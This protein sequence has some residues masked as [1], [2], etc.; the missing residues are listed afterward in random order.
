MGWM[1]VG[2]PQAD[3]GEMA[4]YRVVFNFRL[5]AKVESGGIYI[6]LAP[7]RSIWKGPPAPG[8]QAARGCNLIYT[9]V[10]WYP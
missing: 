4:G 3:Q 6:T 2:F 7:P 10:S 1:V 8:C 9:Y 5:F